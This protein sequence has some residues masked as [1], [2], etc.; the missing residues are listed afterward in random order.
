MTNLDQPFQ[1][2]EYIKETWN[3]YPPEKRFDIMR[4]VRDR[5][6]SDESPDLAILVDQNLLVTDEELQR[7]ARQP[8]QTLSEGWQ[9][10]A[11]TY[12]ATLLQREDYKQTKH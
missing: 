10:V 9:R 8:I 5:Q 11:G 1:L 3:A 2:E 12:V 6:L 7:L 4:R